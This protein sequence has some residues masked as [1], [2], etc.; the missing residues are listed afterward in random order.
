MTEAAQDPERLRLVLPVE[1]AAARDEHL[2]LDQTT[3]VRLTEP[4]ALGQQ[5]AGQQRGRSAHRHSTNIG[6]VWSL[7]WAARQNHG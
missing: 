3:C 2:A 7:L 4:D 1:V 6:S 5:E